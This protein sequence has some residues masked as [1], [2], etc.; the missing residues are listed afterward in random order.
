M[1][2][3][4]LGIDVSKGRADIAIINQSGTL[5]WRSW[6]LGGFPIAGLRIIP[7][8]NTPGSACAGPGGGVLAGDPGPAVPHPPATLARGLAAH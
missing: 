2:C 3:I 1:E 6:R 5:S 4:G 8:P 7:T